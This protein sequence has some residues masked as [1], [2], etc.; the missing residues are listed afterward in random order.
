M[1]G[2]PPQIPEDQTNTLTEYEEGLISSLNRRLAEIK[3]STDEA[4]E[5]YFQ[6][7]LAAPEHR[8]D[9]CAHPPSAILY[10]IN[11]AEEDLLLGTQFASRSRLESFKNRF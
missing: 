5:E 3:A 7:L 8:E 4:M 10:L 11:G 2:N 1:T 9:G 6:G